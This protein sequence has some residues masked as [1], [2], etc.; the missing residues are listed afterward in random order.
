MRNVIAAG[1]F[2]VFGGSA[3]AQDCGSPN[4]QLEM[5]QCAHAAFQQA[6][7][8]LNDK[9][10]AILKRL[11]D[12]GSANL[13]RAAQRVWVPFRDAECAFAA[14]PYEGGSMQPMVV[15]SCLE[16]LTNRRVADFDAY[17]ACE[18]VDCVVPA[19]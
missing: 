17:L 14:S 10:Q 13:F 8:A 9:Y 6:D 1:V 15:S 12:D 3:L 2:L 19:E 7:A 4:T 18:D 11:G 16:D 5:N